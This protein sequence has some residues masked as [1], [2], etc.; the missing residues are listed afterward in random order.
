MSKRTATASRCLMIAASFLLDTAAISQDNFEEQWQDGR[1]GFEAAGIRKPLAHR[2][3]IWVEGRFNFGYCEA[4]TSPQER[5]EEL[6]R[7]DRDATITGTDVG[8]RFLEVAAVQFAA[9][10][11]AGLVEKPTRR[12]CLIRLDV[13]RRAMADALGEK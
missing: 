4:W 2:L 7:F 11:K 13:S 1:A 10:R 6:H 5:A 3:M 12:D 9:G 8:V